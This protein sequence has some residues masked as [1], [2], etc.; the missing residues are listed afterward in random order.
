ME[1]SSPRDGLPLLSSDLLQRQE[2]SS[3]SS[4]SRGH[5]IL[6]GDEPSYV[7]STHWSTIMGSVNDLKSLI[8]TEDSSPSDL[9]D[10]LPDCDTLLCAARPSSLDTVLRILPPRLQVDRYLSNYFRS[11]YLASPIVHTF[12]FQR[13]YERFCGN[14]HETPVL[15]ISIL[16]SILSTS[17]RLMD[18]TNVSA[19]GNFVLRQQFL[20]AAAQCLM[21]GNYSRPKPLVVEALLM[22]CHCQSLMTSEPSREAALILSLVTR[23]AF[24]CGYHRDPDNLKNL[25]VFEGEMRRRT[26][27]VCKDMDLMIATQVGL[28]N[29]IP[30][31]CYDTKLP[32][33]LSDTDFDED[34]QQLPPSKPEIEPTPILFWIVKDRLLTIF[35]KILRVSISFG[36]FTAGYLTQLEESLCQVH[37]SIPPS[38]RI[39][40]LSQSFADGSDIVMARFVCEIIFQKCVCVLHRRMMAQDVKLSSEV[41]IEAAA[42]IL[43]HMV[44][45]YRELQPGGQLQNDRWM[46]SSAVIHNFL[47]ATMILAISI[48]QD[49]VPSPEQGQGIPAYQKRLFHLEL[50][51]STHAICVDLGV[52][53]REAQR[54]ARTLE[55]ILPDLPLSRRASSVGGYIDVYGAA[56]SMTAYS[57]TPPISTHIPPE[58]AGDKFEFSDVVVE[59]VDW[60]FLDQFLPGQNSNPLDGGLYENAT[61]LY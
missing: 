2:T 3:E 17:A 45:V 51:T 47:L 60:T 28:P 15:W 50:L 22:F 9:D 39:R 40:P 33:N 48:S 30:D 31:D 29:Y 5:L 59:D 18:S 21:L 55:T 54:V 58:N 34:T 46:L 26:W 27:V 7:G 10:L 19:D 13:Q 56:P 6:N 41:S 61:G 23:L 36:S 11:K 1:T 35:N 32:S 20:T 25:S 38:L 24:R 44:D 4:P 49:H 52:M 57:K 14:P 12:Q 37:A 42:T 43:R 16:M 8:A 53:S